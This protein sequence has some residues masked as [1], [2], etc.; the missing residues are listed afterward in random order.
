MMKLN[1]RMM[2]KKLVEEMLRCSSGKMIVTSDNQ[3]LVA[4]L[5]V[6]F[7]LGWADLDYSLWFIYNGWCIQSETNNRVIVTY[8]EDIVSC[9]ADDLEGYTVFK[10]S[11]WIEFGF[12]RYNLEVIPVDQFFERSEG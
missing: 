1:N 2:G 11:T 4:E 8:P 7:K 3:L 10:L 6:L 5:G 9:T 12:H